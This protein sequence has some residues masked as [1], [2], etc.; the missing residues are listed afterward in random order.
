MAKGIRVTSQ[1]GHR[2]QV[3]S[4][5]CLHMLRSGSM[6]R[7]AQT[8]RI[9]RGD[10]WLALFKPFCVCFQSGGKRSLVNNALNPCTECSV[11]GIVAGTALACPSPWA[12]KEAR[13][14]TLG[15]LGAGC[16]TCCEQE[17]EGCK[18]RVPGRKCLQ[19]V[20][21]AQANMTVRRRVSVAEISKAANCRHTLHC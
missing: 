17:W 20:A 4:G 16:S 1:N 12:L 19:S 5:H 14:P 9:R 10:R 6:H 7:G 8:F 21:S 18:R 2:L 3:H 13:L 11:T 15:I